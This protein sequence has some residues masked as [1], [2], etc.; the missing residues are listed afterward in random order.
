VLAVIGHSD[1]DATNAALSIYGPQCMPFFIP[2]ATVPDIMTRAF[3]NRWSSVYRLIPNDNIQAHSIV[4]F[5]QGKL[6]VQKAIVIIHED[7]AYGRRLAALIRKELADAELGASVH[8]YT[9][10]DTSTLPVDTITGHDPG[11][12]VCVG[13]TSRTCALMR[14]LRKAYDQPILMTEGFFKREF[15]SYFRSPAASAASIHEKVYMSF[16]LKLDDLPKEG[17]R[18][19]RLPKEDNAVY[20]WLGADLAKMI[21]KAALGVARSGEPLNREAFLKA[22][23]TMSFRRADYYLAKYRFNEFRDNALGTFFIYELAHS[24]KDQGITWKLSH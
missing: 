19:E 23:G 6:N 3:E 12:V 14:D 1:S 11:L 10:G 18:K 21:H 20:Y 9:L 22:F 17:I 2:L 13:Y 4:E 16:Y 24:E 5:C 15:L 7:N 8:V